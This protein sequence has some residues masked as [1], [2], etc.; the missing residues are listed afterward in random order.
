MPANTQAP[1]DGIIHPINS[2]PGKG[3][4]GN[5]TGQRYLIN[6]D[7]AGPSQAWGELRAHANDIIEYQRIGGIGRWV[8]SHSPVRGDKTPNFVLNLASGRQLRWNGEDWVY[9][10]DGVYAPGYWRLSL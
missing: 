5:E 3:L 9:T 7:I 4:P 2:F 6:H 8:V 1:I 10:I